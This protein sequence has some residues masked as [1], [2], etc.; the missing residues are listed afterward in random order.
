MLR[1]PG[2]RN[3]F[4][5]QALSAIGDS[6]VPLALA[7]AVL[8]LTSSPTTLGLVLLAG[9]LPMIV[10]LL[11]GGSVGDR[12]PRR[13][14]MIASDVARFII[15]GAAAAL[16]LTDR[17]TPLLLGLLA[18]GASVGAAFFQPA[19]AGLLPNLVPKTSIQQANATLGAARSG[20]QIGAIGLSGVLVTTIGVG[21]AFLID[22]LTFLLG[23][24]FLTAIRP[25]P[26]DPTN[27]TDPAPGQVAGDGSIDAANR[28]ARPNLAATVTAGWRE[29]ASRRWLWLSILN[30]ALMN[31]LVIAPFLVLGPFIADRDLGG[32]GAWATLGVSA[33]IGGLAGNAAASRWK[34]KHPLLTVYMATVLIVPLLVLLTIPAS[35]LL[36]AP[37][38]GLGLAQNAFFNV[39]HATA[40]QTRIPSEALSSVTS[41]SML[42][43]LVA[44][45]VGLAAAGPVADLTSTSTVLMVAALWVIGS[46]AVMT[47]LPSTRSIRTS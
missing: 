12:L 13:S 14:V 31:L 26:T 34:P 16:L 29:V 11:I 22:A 38:A 27:P 17:A 30:I 40:I 6:L 25:N 15:Q 43:T 32:A 9:R 45:P 42:G 5:A 23:A 18:A 4:A 21:W 41:I 19:A 20:A 7:F 24:L 10:F 47:A 46:A 39:I 1:V 3:F 36:L 28:A 44:V 8:G 33:A 2:F 37:A 35:L